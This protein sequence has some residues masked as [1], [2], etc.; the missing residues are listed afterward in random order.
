MSTAI[1]VIKYRSQ[2][3][4]YDN[5]CW[6]LVA[7]DPTKTYRQ[8]Y[9]EIVLSVPSNKREGIPAYDHVRTVLNRRRTWEIPP[10]PH[11]INE[12]DIQGRWKRTVDGRRF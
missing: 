3:Q 1:K 8:V 6:I 4:R 10:V 12:I 11:S 2:L 7:Q 5:E 9:D